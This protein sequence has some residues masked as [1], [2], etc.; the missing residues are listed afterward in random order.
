MILEK[1]NEINDIKHIPSSEYDDLAKEIRA[2]IVESVSRTGGHLASNLGS[3]ELTMALHLAFN[4]PKDKIIWDVGHQS[5]THKIL[6]G[7]KDQFDTMRQYGGISG[8]PKRAESPCDV[9]DTGHSSTSISAGLGMVYAR[10]L[11]G[12]NYSVV[13]VIGDG[14]MTGGMVYEAINNAGRLKKNFIIVLND[15]EMSISENVGGISQHLN[16]IRIDSGYNQLKKGVSKALSS[17]PI[18][19]SGLNNTVK[20][21]KDGIRQ[22]LIQ[23]HLIFENM[24]I[25]CIGPV[26]GHNVKDMVRIFKEAKRY[27][28]AVI[29]HVMTTK[30]NGY[31]PAENNP[32]AYHGVDPFDIV[33]GKPIRTKTVRSYTDTFSNVICSLADTNPKVVAITA[34]MKDGTGLKKFAKLYP[35]RFFD[36]GIAEEHAVTFAAGLAAGGMKPVVAVYSSFMQRAYDQIVHD[37]ALQKLPVVLAVDRAGIVGADGATHQGIFDIAYLS[38]IPNMTVMAPKNRYE[39]KKMM[40]FAVNEYDGPIAI[41]YPRGDAF[42]GMKEIQE[43]IELGKSELI[44]EGDP[45]S[46]IAI[47]ALGTMVKTAVDATADLSVK[48]RIINMRFAAPLDEA[49]IREVAEK[50]ENIIC[51][52]EGIISGGF[53]EHVENVLTELDYKGTIRHVAVPKRFIEHGCAELLKKKIGLDADSVRELILSLSK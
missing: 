17:I 24:G 32:A 27:E 5:Y 35:S 15:N 34:A 16:S 7:R 52:E 10:D 53:C 45:D 3:V 51:M 29:V 49:C 6:T 48:P 28:G 18:A 46:K 31:K 44:S 33:T 12:D 22:V 36:V 39:M 37:V 14:S 50:Y 26:N 42:G 2:F 43:P 20:R 47:L 9:F 41:R 11:A 25:L 38:G 19:G 30:G 4:L 1:I 40:E 8:F 23:D 21:S 13:S